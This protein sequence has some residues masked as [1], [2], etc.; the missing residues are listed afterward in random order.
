MKTLR[1]RRTTSDK[2]PSTIQSA[3]GHPWVCSLSLSLVCVVFFLCEHHSESIDFGDWRCRAE[4]SNTNQVQVPHL[5]EHLFPTAPPPALT[6]VLTHHRFDVI[7]LSRPPYWP[8]TLLAWRYFVGEQMCD[9][10]QSFCDEHM[11]APY[12]LSGL[13]PY[14]VR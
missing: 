10:A 8:K 9:D 7:Y 14:D 11:M 3:C 6:R 2:T 5:T 13:N 4:Q 1:L 12:M